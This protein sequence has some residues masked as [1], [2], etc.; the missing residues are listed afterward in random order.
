M[1]LDLL[2]GKI[3][4]ARDIV[5]LNAGA[6]IYVSGIAHTLADGIN[7]AADMLDGGKAMQKLQALI[8][9]TNA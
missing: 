9:T 7:T 5:L 2:S 6:A 4:P 8:A 1:I 3:G